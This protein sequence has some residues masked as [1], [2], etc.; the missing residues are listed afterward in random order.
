MAAR[1]CALTPFSTLDS[2]QGAL[3]TPRTSS[4]LSCVNGERRHNGSLQRSE[5][6]LRLPLRARR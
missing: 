2:P 6:A 1:S 5:E 3:R 4:A